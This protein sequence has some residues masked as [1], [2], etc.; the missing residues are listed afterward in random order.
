MT[1]SMETKAQE[2]EAAF[3][4]AGYDAAPVQNSPVHAVNVWLTDT[5]RVP[6]ATVVVSEDGY[7]WGHQYEH[8]AHR[9]KDARTVVQHVVDSLRD[10]VETGG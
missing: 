5:D 9:D 4:A 3:V 7:Y 10:G 6:A 1:K 8:N 2:L